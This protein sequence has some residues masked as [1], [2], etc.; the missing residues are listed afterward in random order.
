MNRGEVLSNYY[1]NTALKFEWWIIDQNIQQNTSKIGF[2]LTGVRSTSG[3]ISARKFKVVINMEVFEQQNSINLSNNQVIL[4]GEKVIYHDTVGNGGFNYYFEGAIY[5]HSVNTSSSGSFDLDK[6][7]RFAWCDDL[8]NVTD[9]DNIN[10]N[11]HNPANRVVEVRLSMRND[12]NL[13]T[14]FAVR[15]NVAAG[16]NTIILTESEKENLLNLM[17]NKQNATIYASVISD[18]G[19]PT[20]WWIQKTFNLKI[21]NAMPELT[22]FN[23]WEDGTLGR[24]VDTRTWNS[25]VQHL[26]RTRINISNRA[27]VANHELKL[28]KRARFSHYLVSYGNK[29]DRI[30]TTYFYHYLSGSFENSGK[31]T[32]TLTGYD[33]RGFSATVVKEVEVMPYHAPII[34]K[35]TAERLEGVSENVKINLDAIISNERNKND[36]TAIRIRTRKKSGTFGDYIN[37]R[38]NK[39]NAT[40]YKITE[41]YIKLSSED[42]HDIEVEVTDKVKTT[43][44]LISIEKG[45]FLFR[46]DMDNKE[47]L[48]DEKRVLT[49]E[50]LNKGYLL[51]EPTNSQ[52]LVQGEQV[53]RLNRIVSNFGDLGVIEENKIKIN[54]KC[55]LKLSAT[56]FINN[57][58][59]GT[60]YGWLKIKKGSDTVASTLIPASGGFLSL[61]VTESIVSCSENDVISLVLEYTSGNNGNIRQYS[62]NTRLFLQEI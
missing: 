9:E 42:E 36:I 7:N 27:D 54:K 20:E 59:A 2:K 17:W 10:I 3:W 53:I 55:L 6:I 38:V 21:V 44:Q 35:F 11:I 32:I 12:N 39:L 16:N 43:T 49:I 18:L 62:A 26:N 1:R 61:P 4:S 40:E 52:N 33:S 14:I 41:L 30:N 15:Q 56:A 19:R 45:R 5:Q 51:V 13:D 25:V 31:Q 58:T 47:F 29:V 50:D 8:P 60:G 28:K 34:K 22:T 57:T 46:F 37:A 24:L 48:V 23:Y